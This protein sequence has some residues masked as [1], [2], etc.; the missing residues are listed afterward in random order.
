MNFLVN[1]LTGGLS[2]IIKDLTTAYSQKLD[3]K[4]EQERIAAD[5]RIATLEDQKEVI[6][7][8]QKDKYERWMRMVFAFPFVVYVWKLVIWDKIL[9]WGV[10]DDLSS[11]LW[12]VF[13]IILGN[14]FVTSVVNRIKK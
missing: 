9:G 8:A 7:Q 3:A 4:T 6:L 1:I 11:T 14:Y 13:Y 10:T 12:T 2:T 5:E